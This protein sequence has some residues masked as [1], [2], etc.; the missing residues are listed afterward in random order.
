VNDAVFTHADVAALRIMTGQ[1]AVRFLLLDHHLG[2]N[3]PSV[4]QL[5]RVV[6]SNSDATV[7]AV[8]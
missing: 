5:G 6:F 2:P 8:D 7:V 3:D 1:Y 4:L